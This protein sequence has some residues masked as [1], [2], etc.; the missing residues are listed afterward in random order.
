[1]T[2]FKRLFNEFGGAIKKQSLAGSNVE[3]RAGLKPYH[4]DNWLEI[5]RIK[6][7]IALRE[8]GMDAQRYANFY[9]YAISRW[10][11]RLP[12]RKLNVLVLGCTYSKNLPHLL[13]KNNRV[14][15]VLVVDSDSVVLEN[16][17]DEKKIGI[18][19]WQMDLNTDPLPR[20]SFDVIACDNSLNYLRGI[21]HIGRE[22]ERVIDPA[23]LFLARE[24]IGPN[25]MQFSDSQMAL[26]N[27]L[28][29]ALPEKYRQDVSSGEAVA[30]QKAP[31]LADMQLSDPAKAV[32]SE[33]IEK[34]I[35]F[36]FR[37]MEEIALGGTL[38][39]PLMINIYTHFG[40]DDKE[41]LKLLDTL[42]DVEMRLIEGGLLK[43]DYKSFIC[44]P[45]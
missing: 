35:N 40:D 37:V 11:S 4:V 8:Q 12:A 16:L 3:S 24:Y 42:I 9:D 27:A 32:R 28:L 39:A 45:A 5:F 22:I 14:G 13:L 29:M 21:K 17:L 1:M 18:E 23:G 19:C 44:R 2:V 33:E 10:G 15:N 34:M 20:G 41:T 31:E 25:R 7:S 43:S 6:E 26:V 38:L 36:H 30:L